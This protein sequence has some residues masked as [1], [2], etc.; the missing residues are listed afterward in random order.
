MQTLRW[1]VHSG[2]W[3]VVVM[4]PDGSPGVTVRADAGVS[5]PVLPAL[6]GELLAA[7]ITACLIG[8][9]LIVISVR[10]AAGRR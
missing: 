10:L 2:D 3:M 7:G 8:A 1:T 4:N 5:S 9:A 6:A